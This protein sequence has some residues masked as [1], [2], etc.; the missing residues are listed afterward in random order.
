[1]SIR[2]ATFNREKSEPVL[3]ISASLPNGSTPEQMNDLIKKM[4]TFFG[5]I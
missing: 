2:A 3:H 1:M 5:G 4:E